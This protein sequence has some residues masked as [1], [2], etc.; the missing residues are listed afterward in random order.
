MRKVTYDSG[1]AR[2]SH[3][4]LRERACIQDLRV[5]LLLKSCASR[6]RTHARARPLVVLLRVRASCSTFLP[7]FSLS[8]KGEGAAAAGLLFLK[9]FAIS[10]IKH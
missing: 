10:P 5:A 4:S 8:F 1:G 7:Y 9:S 6:T 2:V 3:C